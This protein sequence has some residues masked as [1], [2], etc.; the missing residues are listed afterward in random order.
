MRGRVAAVIAWGRM[1]D[2]ES[3]DEHLTT[4]K[5]SFGG[6]R[7]PE[8]DV[9]DTDM[10]RPFF[11]RRRTWLTAIALA[12]LTLVGTLVRPEVAGEPTLDPAQVAVG[13]G[14]FICIAFLWLTEALP[15][16][17]TA[18]LVPV[19]ATATGVMDMTEALAGFAHP[20]IF[21]FFGGFALA[22]AMAYQGVD[23]WIAGRV[24]ALGRGGF[25]RIAALL[26]SVTAFLSMWMSNTA[27]AA[28][29]LPL[30]LG[31]LGRMDV[32][33]SGKN[34]LFLLLGVAY[35]ASIGG[36]GT[37]IGSPPNAIAAGK[38]GIGFGEW[39]RFGVPAVLVLLPL[40]TGLLWLLFRP[41]RGGRI[42]AAVGTFVFNWHRKVMLAVFA[43]AALCW[44]FGAKLGEWLG[45]GASMDT[46]VALAAV[47]ALLFFRVVRWRD[48]DRGTDWGVLLLFGGGIT[49]SAVLGKTG[50]SL[51][52]AREFTALVSAWP[53][54]LV[55]AAVVGFVIFLTELSS[56]TATA[57]LLVPIFFAVASE[58]GMS[59]ESLVLPLAVA[60]SCAFMLP[61]ATPPNA[62]VFGTG[63][64]PQREMMRAGI[65]LNLVFIV[66]LTVL[67]RLLL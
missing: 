51:Y 10:F 19:L 27:T 48:I 49:L 1:A 57:A 40:M 22:S 35:S 59:A 30:V 26:F 55:I 52:L 42:E 28:M 58:L 61:V 64:V 50:A 63:L 34:A 66:A 12:G 23:R 36:V 56:N 33:R 53:T 65:V 47:L 31:I 8:E 46:L 45:V 37:L 41:E 13:L 5:A 24:V 54:L 60:A 15:L 14:I 43:A 44:I 32:P 2:D 67:A 9:R 39:M 21:L 20:L 3:R 16:A 25:L 6:A 38:L 18:L 7:Y 4:G 11:R 62:I 29:M 17:A